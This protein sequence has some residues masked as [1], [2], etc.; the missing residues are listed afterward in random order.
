MD[1]LVVLAQYVL[2]GLGFLN[3]GIAG[4]VAIRFALITYY[5]D[6]PGL[7][8][9]HIWT[10]GLSYSIYAVM[11]ATSRMNTLGDSFWRWLGYS[12]ATFAGTAALLI[13]GR[14]QWRLPPMKTQKKK[15]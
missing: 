15:P 2:V 3:V 6:R 13:I 14:H 1:N 12:V 10:V 8:P 11:A 5:E 4:T 9:W 7:L